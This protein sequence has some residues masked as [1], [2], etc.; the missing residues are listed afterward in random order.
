MASVLKENLRLGLLCELGSYQFAS[1]NYFLINRKKKSWGRRGSAA[2]LYL[3]AFC[4][5]FSKQND[6]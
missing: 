1:E 4:L 5:S 2:T 6:E 3:S